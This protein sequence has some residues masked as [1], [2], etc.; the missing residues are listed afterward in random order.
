MS[1]HFLMPCRSHPKLGQ[2]GH[3]QYILLKKTM[4]YYDGIAL[5]A[6]G[7]P[8]FGLDYIVDEWIAY[9]AHLSK[10]LY[11][12][13]PSPGYGVNHARQQP[14]RGEQIRFDGGFFRDTLILR[15]SWRSNQ[16]PSH[17]QTTVLLLE[18]LLP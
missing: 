12:A 15:R 13:S 16:Q 18:L 7:T 3:K 11:I 4:T 10:A 2:A 9:I 8:R 5:N 6:L 1:D 17:C 14:V